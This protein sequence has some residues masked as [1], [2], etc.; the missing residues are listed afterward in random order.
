VTDRLRARARRRVVDALLVPAMAIASGLAMASI[1]VLFTPT[2]PLTAYGVLFSA[3][4]GCDELSRCALLTTLERSTPLV[5]T[6]LS[7]VVAF[8]SGL[9]SIGQ[10][11]QFV[12]GATI[13]AWLG[14]AVSLPP[15]LHPIFILTVAIAG[16]AAYGFIPAIL[17]VGLQVNEIISTIILNKLAVLFM[18]YLVNFP[19]RADAGSTARSPLIDQSAHLP[20]FLPGSQWGVGWILAVSAV[21]FV[22]FHL[23][24]TAAGYE[25][26]MAGEAPAFAR[27]GGVVTAR[28]AIRGML[29]SGGLSGLAG[30]IEV[31]GVS[32]QIV[33]GFSAGLGFDG[34][35]VAI[36]GLA[37]PVGVFFV[38]ILFAGIRLGAQLGLQ[39]SAEIP[40]E[41]GGGI[42][43]LI[44]LFV[45]AQS[46]YLGLIDRVRDRVRR[47]R[48]SANA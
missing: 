18:T 7:A 42:L 45:S 32:R 16:G 25:Q 35:L 36:L 41:L 5:L 24:R 26:R 1:F 44:I 6:G 10:E 4:F 3:G 21:V 20:S 11:G 23:W 27:Y 12:V 31:L 9:F 14:Y 8:R 37:H 22:A 43:A 34:V 48:G 30:G 28:A 2:P 17:K 47:L 38:A 46:A 15:L 40:R 39:V 13:A 19:M 33:P 29:I